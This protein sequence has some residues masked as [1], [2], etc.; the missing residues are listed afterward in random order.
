[1]RIDLR[2]IGFGIESASQFCV[3]EVFQLFCLRMNSAGV[4]AGLILKILFPESMRSH[5]V[6]RAVEALRCQRD[7]VSLSC[8]ISPVIKPGKDAAQGQSTAKQ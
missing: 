4:D 1:M 2:R 8:D 5:Q 3:G 7:Q 6:L